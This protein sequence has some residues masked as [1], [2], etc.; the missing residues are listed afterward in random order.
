M[1]AWVRI[2]ALACD[3]VDSDL[4]LVGG[5][6]AWYSGFLNYLQLASHE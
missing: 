3:N 1:A 6:F 5:V 4:E 2:P